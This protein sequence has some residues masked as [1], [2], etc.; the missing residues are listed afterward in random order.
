[1]A[2]PRA[3]VAYHPSLGSTRGRPISEAHQSR[4]DAIAS[5][6]RVEFVIEPNP[7]KIVAAAEGADFFLTKNAPL[8][9]GLLER[10]K[11]LRL[12]QVATLYGE[13]V[14]IDAAAAAG[15]PVSFCDRPIVNSVADHSMALLLEM[16]RSIPAAI[17]AAREGTGRPP[18]P[19][20]PD[21]SAYNWAQVQGVRPLKGMRLGILGMGEIAR[22]FAVRA[23]AFG[24][25]VRYWNRSPL[26]EW[27]DRRCGASPTSQD[28]LF[29]N[30]DVI[31]PCVG[32]N[33]HTRHIIGEEAIRAMPHGSYLI[34][35]GR[36][37]LVD[38]EALRAAL[39][40]GHI[41]GAGLDVFDLEP[42]PTNHPLLGAPGLI[43]TPHVAGGDDETLV[44]E[45][46]SWMANVHR[47]IDGKPPKNI[48]NG[49]EWK[50]D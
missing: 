38:Q 16:V 42:F 3:V 49:V 1:V 25:E 20:R 31:Y 4:I 34:N 30:S 27:I 26:A 35:I 33:E 47:V 11:R 36:G 5:S 50:T 2:T 39:E 6:E 23:R 41:A 14:D 15:V 43:P 48:V 13:K 9:E 17:Q 22:E 40:D 12:I 21:G 10:A 37:P 46:E 32:L 8:P 18:S 19:T 29:R 7:E 44:H 24:M 45:L 28:D